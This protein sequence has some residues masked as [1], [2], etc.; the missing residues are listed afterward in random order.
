MPPA[1]LALPT[2]GSAMASA[3][4]A[5]SQE[6]LPR[7]VGLFAA[8]AVIVGTTIG[9]GI[10]RVPATVATRLGEPGPVLLA[11]TLGGMLALFGALTLAELAAMFPR[12]GG[13]LRFWR[14]PSGRCPPF[15]SVGASSP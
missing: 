15:S 9:S 1:R 2:Q 3:P 8:V 10:F 11:W 6:R 4:P 13:V 7:S 5:P 12:S 14:R